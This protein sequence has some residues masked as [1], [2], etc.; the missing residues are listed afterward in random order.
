MCFAAGGLSPVTE[1][2]S[3]GT[4]SGSQADPPGPGQFVNLKKKFATLHL[5]LLLQ[6][7]SSFGTV[8]AV[9]VDVDGA[10][11]GGIVDQQDRRHHVLVWARTLHRACDCVVR[12]E[13]LHILLQQ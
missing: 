5:Q 11:G 10:G 2:L 4:F 3:Q 13:V 6:E 9:A 12:D 8:A 7:L 1:T